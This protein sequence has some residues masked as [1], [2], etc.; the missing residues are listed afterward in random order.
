MPFQKLSPSTETEVLTLKEGGMVDP[1]DRGL[2]HSACP[3]WFWQLGASSSRK[4]SKPALKCQP[5]DF[6]RSLPTSPP[7]KIKFPLAIPLAPLSL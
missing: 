1:L 7:F 3:K 2:P 6:V 5:R 4:N